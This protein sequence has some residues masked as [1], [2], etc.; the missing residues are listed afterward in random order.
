MYSSRQK[1][2]LEKQDQNRPPPPQ[3]EAKHDEIDA[4]K[5]HHDRVVRHMQQL[6]NNTHDAQKNAGQPQVKQDGDVNVLWR[7]Q[8]ITKTT[9]T[10]MTTPS[11]FQDREN[12]DGLK[13][14]PVP[15]AYK[16]C[17]IQTKK[18]AVSAYDRATTP[19]CKQ[20]I[21]N[22]TCLQKAG[23]L[24]D[25]NLRRECK[26]QTSGRNFRS[27][28]L[29]DYADGPKARVVFLFSLHGRALRQVKRLFKAV[30]H[31]DHYYFIHVDSVS[32]WLAKLMISSGSSFY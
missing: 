22:V 26:T 28:P 3:P 27:V 21:R 17:D 16:N 13:P 23:L 10:T 12:L 11:S 2:P 1:W 7:G 15:D 5:A 6:M 31:R 25:T 30:Y 19:E 32:W 9:T 4:R 20:L 18:D 14:L 8:A 24:Y 29:S